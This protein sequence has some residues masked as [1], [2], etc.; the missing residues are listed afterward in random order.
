[1]NLSK[2]K[3]SITKIR[4]DNYI[5]D[6]PTIMAN[7]FNNYTFILQLQKILLKQFHPVINPFFVCFLR[8]FIEIR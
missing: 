2:N 3:H 5:I 8:Q 6:D 4:T 7:A 1:M